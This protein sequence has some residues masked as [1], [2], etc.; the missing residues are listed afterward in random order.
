MML[1]IIKMRTVFRKINERFFY[2]INKIQQRIK[3]FNGSKNKSN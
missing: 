3:R 1:D 2:F